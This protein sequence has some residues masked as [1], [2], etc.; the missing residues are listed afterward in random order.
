M[1]TAKLALIDETLKEEQDELT[2]RLDQTRKELSEL[3][4]ILGR[5][6]SAR[7]ALEGTS[8]TGKPMSTRKATKPSASKL[9]V[10]NFIAEELGK[11]KVLPLIELKT[12]IEK[13]VTETGYSL[14]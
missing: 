6:T 7:A 13:R 8:I 5:L 1:T 2:K 14:I 4:A 10:T 3:E 12:R 9:Q 11:Y